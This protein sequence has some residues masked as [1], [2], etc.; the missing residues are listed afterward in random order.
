MSVHVCTLGIAHKEQCY[1][2][3]ENLWSTVIGYQFMNCHER[4]GTKWKELTG[5]VIYFIA[6]DSLPTYTYALMI[7][8]AC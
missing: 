8:A 5:T 7:F 2:N 4:K 1:N 6:K 3:S